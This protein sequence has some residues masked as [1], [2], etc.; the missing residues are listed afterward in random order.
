MF[1][2]AYERIHCKIPLCPAGGYTNAVLL[3]YR[4]GAGGEG[5]SAR[6]PPCLHKHPLGRVER[7]LCAWLTRGGPV[8][9]RKGNDAR[10]RRCAKGRNQS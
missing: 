7:G 8:R 9:V 6:A 5:I 3:G 2:L 10:A 1:S 4:L